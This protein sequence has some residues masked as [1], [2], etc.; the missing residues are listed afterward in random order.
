MRHGVSKHS[1]DVPTPLLETFSVTTE[2]IRDAVLYVIH[3]QTHGMAPTPIWHAAETRLRQPIQREDAEV[4]LR[5]LVRHHR[6][7][8]LRRG[9]YVEEEAD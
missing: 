1:R 9:L 8:L 7:L 4:A 2:Q 5:W 3:Q 6:I